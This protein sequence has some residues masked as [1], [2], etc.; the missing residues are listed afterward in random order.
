M[1]YVSPEHSIELATIHNVEDLIEALW[2]LAVLPT[3]GNRASGRIHCSS[4]VLQ[5]HRAGQRH[6]RA[7]CQV[8]FL[9]GNDTLGQIA[10]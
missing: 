1:R 6:N 5:L 4:R 10:I 7:F 2:I 8:R 9:L 3:Q